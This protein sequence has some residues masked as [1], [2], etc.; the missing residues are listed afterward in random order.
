MRLTSKE[1]Q[2][3]QVFDKADKCLIKPLSKALMVHYFIKI[4]LTMSN[5]ADGTHLWTD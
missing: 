5:Y 3:R 4:V 1:S 2:A